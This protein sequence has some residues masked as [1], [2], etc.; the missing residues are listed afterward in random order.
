MALNAYTGHDP[1]GLGWYCAWATAVSVFL[2][3]VTVTHLDDDKFALPVAAVGGAVRRLLRRDRAGAHRA[4]PYAAGWLAIL[5]AIFTASGPGGLEMIGKWEDLAT[6]W[7]VFATAVVLGGF[8]AVA[9]RRR[10]VPAA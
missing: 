4:S 5:E 10:A 7:V 3:L 8:A 6:G 9:L 1:A 2:G